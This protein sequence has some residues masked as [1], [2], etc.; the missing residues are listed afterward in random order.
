MIMDPLALGR[1]EWRCH[2]SWLGVEGVSFVLLRVFKMISF[3]LKVYIF[4]VLLPGL[5]Y[6]WV[7]GAHSKVQVG[8]RV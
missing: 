2:L 3:P 5:Y 7:V 1:V 4:T 8:D 6:G